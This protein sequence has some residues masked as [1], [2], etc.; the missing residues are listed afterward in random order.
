[1]HARLGEIDRTID[2]FREVVR[3]Q[4][5]SAEARGNLDK[6]LEWRRQGAPSR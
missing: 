4:P 6:A 1:M 2:C 5:D 3:L